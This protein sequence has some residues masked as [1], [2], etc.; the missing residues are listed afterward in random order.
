M[1]ASSARH[2]PGN[3]VFAQYLRGPVPACAA[4]G[5]SNTARSCIGLQAHGANEQHQTVC[6]A[7]ISAATVEFG[8][9]ELQHTALGE[10][11]CGRA[12]L[13][14]AVMLNDAA[15]AGC[16]LHETTSTLMSMAPAVWP[17]RLG[18]PCCCRGCGCGCGCSFSPASAA[19]RAPVVIICL[20]FGSLLYHHN[21][22]TTPPFTAPTSQFYQHP[23]PL[24]RHAPS[25]H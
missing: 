21:Y 18:V 12:G 15:T 5:D 16:P 22:Q 14:T 20:P 23:H 19:R 2:E 6:P 11:Y 1:S 4:T 8:N 7:S 24:A 17:G 13:M 3:L 10:R 9:L 25:I